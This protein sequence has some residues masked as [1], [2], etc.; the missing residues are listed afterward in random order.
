[1]SAPL[2]IIFDPADRTYAPLAPRTTPTGAAPFR[3]SGRASVQ[4]VLQDLNTGWVDRRSA[5]C[6]CFPSRFPAPG[7]AVTRDHSTT[8]D[9]RGI[10]MIRR[11]GSVRCLTALG[12]LL[13]TGSALSCCSSG[14]S[15]TAVLLVGTYNGKA[16][17]YTTIQSAVNAAQPGSYILVAPGD[18]HE[19]DDAPPRAS[20]CTG[21]AL[22]SPRRLPV[23]E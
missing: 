6:R 20:S 23:A 15:S 10:Q 5:A 16:G 21:G 11:N 3:F 17:Q 14:G 19:D 1:M 2:Q 8:S 7:L 9:N 12:A 4:W 13:L 22:Q 18:Y